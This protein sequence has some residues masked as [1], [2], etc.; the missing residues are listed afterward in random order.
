[1]AAFLFDLLLFVIIFFVWACIYMK[2]RKYYLAK[3][4]IDDALDIPQ[5]DSEV[6]EKN[7]KNCDSIAENLPLN[8]ST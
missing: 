2:K 4:T 1:M 7:K 6:L 8:N 3:T 5:V